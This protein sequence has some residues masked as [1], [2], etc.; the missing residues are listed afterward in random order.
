MK[1]LTRIVCA[2][3]VLVLASAGAARG[4]VITFG[5]VDE[6]SGGTP[7]AAAVPPP[8]LTV[9][10]DDGGTPGS[11]TL[12]LAATNL[13]D[14]EF[15]SK[16]FLNLDPNLDPTSLI[17]S[18]PT[19]TGMFDAPIINTKV[20][21]F[22]ADGDGEYD[23]KFSFATTGKDG[24]S[25][26]FRAGDS[27][28]YTVTGIATLT[29]ASFDFLSNPAGGHGPFHTAA[30]VQGIGPSDGSGWVTAPEPATLAMLAIGGL[31]MLAR[32]RRK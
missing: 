27:I 28:Q 20:N 4:G 10:I 3:W 12:T 24:G 11:V 29:A 32:R 30:H 21:E 5:L 2:V 14:S 25:H 26:R 9:T 18:A 6:F 17:F 7:P 1:R 19:K 16:W 22:K 31:A 15:V 23:I 13:T 8:W